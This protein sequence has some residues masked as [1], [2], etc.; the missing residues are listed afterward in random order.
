MPNLEPQ[1]QKDFSSGQITNVANNIVPK[2]SVELAMNV[3]ADEKLGA[4]VS[5]LGT[6]IVGSQ[7]VDGKT[8]LGL[9]DF[10]DT[11]G[12]NH[13]LIGFVNNAGDTQSVGYKVG[14]GTITGLTTQTAG[15]KH[16]MLTYLDSVLIVNGTDSE[17]SYDGSTVITTGGAFDLANIPVNPEVVAE[18][19]DRVYVAR[20]DSDTLYYSSIPA[21]GAVSWT[22]GNGS[23]VIEPEDGGGGI[24]GFGKV[25][26]Y[27]LIFKERSMK[28]WDFDSAFPESLVNI[29]TPSQESVINVAGICAFFSASSRAGTGFYATNGN[30]PEL[31]S[32][33]RVKGIKNWIDAIPASYHANVSGYGDENHCYWSIGDVTVEGRAFTNVVLRWAIKTG[34]W[35]VRSYPSEFRVFSSYVDGSGNNTIVGGDDDG[36]IIELDK[37]STYV[38]YDS[39]AG[40]TVPINWEIRTQEEDFEFNQIKTVGDRLIVNSRGMEGGRVEVYINGEPEPTNTRDIL[41]DISELEIDNITGNY[42]QF[43]IRGSQTGGRATLLELEVPNIKVHQNYGS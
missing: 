40:G 34:E 41:G 9:H 26:G 29:G 15:L 43:V 8:V 7:L 17:K 25:P 22:S 27:L 24:K 33:L 14:T 3:D 35:T 38:D 1:F 16:R 6:G 37:P 28:R 19:L 5:R 13:A 12:S 2:N 10:R 11:S 32:H 31:I 39:G 30:R 20:S 36:T 21:A 42:F 4:L 23:V 18:F